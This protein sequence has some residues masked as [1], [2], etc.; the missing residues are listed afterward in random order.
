M[1]TLD[2]VRTTARLAAVAWAV[3][4]GA[5]VA[6]QAPPGQSARDDAQVRT[7]AGLF[8]ERCAECH[9]ADGKGVAGHDLTRLWSVGATDA[10]VFQTVRNGVPN[11]IMPSSSAPDDQLWAVVAYLRSTGDA[12]SAAVASGNLENGQRLFRTSCATCHRVNGN[13]GRLGPDL[14]RLS[15]SR[16]QL[17]AAIRTPS[18]AIGQGFEPVTLVT[19]DGRRVRAVRKSEDAFSIQVMDTSERLQGYLKSDLRDVVRDTTSLMPVFGTDRLTAT[20]LDD[21]LRFL[22]TLRPATA[23]RRP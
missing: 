4:L 17:V 1:A 15:Q 19:R 2:H 6:A 3:A 23:P 22:G 14:S 18:A 13:G 5:L 21:L 10:Q 9:G 12:P 8:R 7:G 20:D 11:T 16:D